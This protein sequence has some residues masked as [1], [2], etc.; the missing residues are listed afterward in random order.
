M[1]KTKVV[2]AHRHSDGIARI[3]A[4]TSERAGEISTDKTTTEIKRFNYISHDELSEDE[5][6][7]FVNLGLSWILHGW[8]S[9]QFEVNIGEMTIGDDGEPTG[10]EIS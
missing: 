2:A 8:K 9:E 6:K 10:F 4:I 1:E 5:M 7:D 3:A